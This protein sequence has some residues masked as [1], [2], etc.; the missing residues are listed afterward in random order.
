MFDVFVG[1]H[2]SFSRCLQS[3]ADCF[4][5][6]NLFNDLPERRVVR[7]LLKTLK[8]KCPGWRFGYIEFD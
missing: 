6:S 8:N 7:E 5:D 4:K 1:N 2:F 3:L